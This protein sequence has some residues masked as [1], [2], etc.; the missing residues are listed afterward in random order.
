MNAPGEAA[1]AG[2]LHG[3][4]GN[5]TFWFDGHYPGEGTF[6]GAQA[7]PVEM[8]LKTIAAALPN[9][10]ECVTM[11]DDV[12]GFGDSPGYLKPD[13]LVAWAAQ[14]GMTWHIEHDIMIMTRTPGPD[15]P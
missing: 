3:P 6:I 8:D 4:S 1:L 13:A 15:A 10:D 9:V 2:L 14:N 12:R 5:V 11:I 7:S